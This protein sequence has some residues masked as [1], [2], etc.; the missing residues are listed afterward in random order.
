MR[1]LTVSIAGEGEGGSEWG[2]GGGNG[3]E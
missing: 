2:R 1:R 3:G